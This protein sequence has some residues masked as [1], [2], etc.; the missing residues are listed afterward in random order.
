MEKLC[1]TC[2]ACEFIPQQTV[3]RNLSLSYLVNEAP[4]LVLVIDESY[5]AGRETFAMQ[6]VKDLLVKDIS[7]DYCTSIRCIYKPGDLNETELQDAVS[8]CSV[9]T[10]QISGG[11]ALIITGMSGLTQLKIEEEHKPGDLFRH[12]RLGVVLVVP[13]ILSNQMDMNFIIIK[14]RVARALKVLKL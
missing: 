14:A 4:P 10:N 13:A 5:S 9:W 1:E 6:V 12:P 11:R 8:R 2:T 7:F 3:L